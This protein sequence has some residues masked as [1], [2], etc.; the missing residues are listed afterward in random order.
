[1]EKSKKK[2]DIKKTVTN[3]D[4]E[5]IL[6]PAE[7]TSKNV[8]QSCAE[9]FRLYNENQLQID[10]DFQRNFVWKPVVQT[11][12]IDSL[13]KQLPIPSIWIALDTKTEK[14]V[15]IDGLQRVSTIFRFLKGDKWKLNK[16]PDIDTNISGKL[17]S[18]IKNSTP[19]LY[20]RVENYMIPVTTI[21]CDFSKQN[22]MDYL[23]DIFHRLNTGA[24]KL[25]NQEVRNGIYGGNFNNLLK[26]IVRSDE[27]TNI[28]G[29]T[30]KIDR[31]DNEELVL[32]VFS[33][34]D[35]LD[36]YN[37][38]LAKFLNH[39]M[40]EKQNILDNEIEEKGKMLLSSLTYIY[41][42]ID[43]TASVS[44]LGKTVKEALLVGVCKNIDSLT[45]KSKEEFQS[46]FD[47]FINDEEFSE[48]NLTQ[49]LS[50]KDKVQSRLNKSISIFEE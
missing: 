37:G 32:R 42:N 19:K 25:T 48:E 17:L 13:V 47:D 3:S 6:P 33:F 16:L 12:F 5:V 28:I 41:E 43:D 21:S 26:T 38:N 40:S 9:L 4:E 46:L 7:I 45:L 14:R 50:K 15:V 49:G 24:Q 2:R 10:P 20:K 1:M 34:I 35:K 11:R 23:F 31:L 36:E 30:S 44:G 8:E 29:K 18:S 39:Y 22:H 27:W